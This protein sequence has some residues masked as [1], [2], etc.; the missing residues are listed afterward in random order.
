MSLYQGYIYRSRQISTNSF[1]IGILCLKW[2]WIPSHPQNVFKLFRNDIKVRFLIQW[3]LTT[4]TSCAWPVV[5]EVAL[6]VVCEVARALVV[7]EVARVVVCEV[8]RARAR[9]RGRMRA[10]A[11]VVV[12][13][14]A[15]ARRRL[16]GRVRASSSA[17]SRAS[18]SS[19][20]RS[21]ASS[22]ARSRASSS[23]RLRASSSSVRFLRAKFES[24]KTL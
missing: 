7:S 22:S 10:R 6:V 17:R 20:A 5:C 14:V 13:E 16:R 1:L 4:A 2:N 9:L 11:L 3:K 21:W 19:S 15:C 8:S 12:C 24:Q 23:A 18:A